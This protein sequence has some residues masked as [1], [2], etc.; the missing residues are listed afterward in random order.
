M[1]Q[2]ESDLSTPNTI[3]IK[4]WRYQQRSSYSTVM[5]KPMGIVVTT[6]DVDKA[7]TDAF[8]YFPNGTPTPSLTPTSFAYST[9]S[10]TQYA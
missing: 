1:N 4:F 6:A 5:P 9:L 3:A 2:L 8:G 7:I 10:A